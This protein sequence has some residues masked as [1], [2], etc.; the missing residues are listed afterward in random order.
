MLP[1]SVT[2]WCS[3]NGTTS[4][5]HLGW[6]DA[7]DNVDK[8]PDVEPTPFAMMPACKG[9]VGEDVG[10]RE[11]DVFSCYVLQSA[12]NYGASDV[13]NCQNN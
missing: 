13:V 1:A 11:S 7:L 4:G 10:V 12:T 3:S 5:R 8:L 6:I 2:V 9:L